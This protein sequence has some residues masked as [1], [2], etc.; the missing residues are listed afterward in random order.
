MK[1]FKNIFWIFLLIAIFNVFSNI[2][3]IEKINPQD[4]TVNIDFSKADVKVVIRYL[5]D[6]TDQNFVI[7]TGVSGEITV[8]SPKKIPRK[9]AAKVI[10]SILELNG[11]SLVPSDKL[12]RVVNKRKAREQNISTEMGREKD[13]IPDEDKII[14]QLIP[15]NFAKATDIEKAIVPLISKDSNITIYTPINILIITD[16]ANNIHRLLKIIENLDVQGAE[17]KTT[18]IPIKYAS[19][20]TIAGHIT[21]VF[22]DPQAQQMQQAHRQAGVN[23]PQGDKRLIKTIADDRTNTVVLLANE[24]DTKTII[25]FVNSL[26]K[27]IDVGRDDIHVYYLENSDAEELAKVLANVPLVEKKPEPGQPQTPQRSGASSMKPNIVADKY[28]NA[29]IINEPPENYATIKKIISQLDIP[30]SQVLVEA[31]IVEMSLDKSLQVGVEWR[32][33]NK[34]TAGVATA[35][36]GSNFGLTQEGLASAPYGGQGLTV[37]LMKGWL[38]ES[39]GIPNIGALLNLFKAD[40]DFN[41]LSTPQIVTMDNHEAE[42]VVSDVIPF[43]T[44][45]RVTD[46]NNVIKTYD[47]KDVGITLK[48]TPHI[49]KQTKM[50][51]MDIL[52]EISKVIDA[53]VTEAVRT[54]KRKAKTSV[55]VQD[56]KT[57]V[58]GGLIRNDKT[59]AESKIPL[60]GDIPFLGILFKRKKEVNSKTN[61]M[62]FITPH[63]INNSNDFDSLTIKKRTQLQDFMDENRGIKTLNKDV[64]NPIREPKAI[65]TT[66]TFIIP[67]EPMTID[68]TAVNY[69]STIIE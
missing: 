60:L 5:S 52:Q 43:V 38:D 40:S 45:S 31:A 21:T 17:I 12:I 68:T 22:G 11:L 24:E 69:D 16:V 23:L 62:I 10:E 47:Y 15:L 64:S 35:A 56:E 32:S 65:D 7:D 46:T 4:D 63:I 30:R 2:Y 26:D 66:S 18:L 50:V 20:K 37:G 6:L 8:I 25:E 33:L 58:I 19:A 49:N 48:L 14:T 9:D 51:R 28:T 13:K 39:K 59:F 61:L 54:S 41:I 3:A 36:V 53:S 34:P 67:K 57:I 29:L 55:I 27:D 44:N 42:I 1:N